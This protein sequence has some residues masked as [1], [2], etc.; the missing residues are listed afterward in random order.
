[1]NI[2]YSVISFHDLEISGNG[3]LF[4]N[5]FFR[6]TQNGFKGPSYQI[7]HLSFIRGFLRGAASISL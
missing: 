4:C 2:L 5:F 3:A 6:L 1:M 7:H